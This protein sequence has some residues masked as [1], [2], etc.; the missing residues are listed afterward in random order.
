M[1]LLPPNRAERERG[2]RQRNEIDKDVEKKMG[3]QRKEGLGGRVIYQ[4]EGRRNQ[5]S[6][7]LSHEHN[8]DKQ[9]ALETYMHVWTLRE[10]RRK[11]DWIIASLLHHCSLTD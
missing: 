4:A 9:A 7:S 10:R 5:K 1:L 3:E 8:S 6:G 2:N 11:G